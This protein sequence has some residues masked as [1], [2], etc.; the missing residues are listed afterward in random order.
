MD[1]VLSVNLMTVVDFASVVDPQ[2]SEDSAP[3]V[4]GAATIS[5]VLSFLQDS[6]ALH[7]CSTSLWLVVKLAVAAF[8]L[9]KVHWDHLS[10]LLLSTV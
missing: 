9:L 10:V 8:S 4:S 6:G 1:F 3:V 2:S 7:R 5:Y